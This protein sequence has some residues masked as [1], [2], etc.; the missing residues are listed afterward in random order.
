M[1]CAEPF[2]YTPPGVPCG[3]VWP[4]RVKLQL[5]V[6]LYTFFPLVSELAQE[7]AA[8]VSIDR[9][10]VRIIGA[11]SDNQWLTKT[12]VMIDLVPNGVRFNKATALSVYERF[13][14]KGIRLNSSMF[15]SYEVLSVRYAGNDRITH[16]FTVV[17]KILTCLCRERFC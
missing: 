1:T 3:C 9:G 8:G 15:G 16:N 13:W 17:L 10:Q 11:N 6:A 2:T 5:A 12:T 4:I 7:I 14:H